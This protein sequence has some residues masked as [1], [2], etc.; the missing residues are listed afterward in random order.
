MSD[1]FAEARMELEDAHDSAG[2][3]YFA[4]DC[5]L[6]QELVTEVLTTYTAVLERA[7][8]EEGKGIRQAW[9]LKLEQ[10]KGEMAHLL[11]HDDH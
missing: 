8:E 6:C 10:L 1:T 5:K 11:E 2:T 4:E 9:G 3:K 7:S